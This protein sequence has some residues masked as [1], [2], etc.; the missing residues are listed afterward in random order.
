M[1]EMALIYVLY[2][3]KLKLWLRNDP[4]SKSFLLC[5]LVVDVLYQQQ[6]LF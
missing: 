2:V 5:N 1:R 6:H 4:V 3:L